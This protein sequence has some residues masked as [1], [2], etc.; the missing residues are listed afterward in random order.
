MPEE[1]I[2]NPIRTTHIIRSNS[3]NDRQSSLV[4]VVGNQ[5][6][7]ESSVLSSTSSAATATICVERN[8]RSAWN[9]FWEGAVYVLNHCLEI[10]GTNARRVLAVNLTL[11]SLVLFVVLLL[12]HHAKWR[13]RQ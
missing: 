7:S 11:V 2:R 6:N 5:T 12:D 9:E 13:R 8:V 4:A 1:S 10:A 3:N